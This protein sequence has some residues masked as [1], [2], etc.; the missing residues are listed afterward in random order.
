[1]VLDEDGREP[2]NGYQS[3]KPRNLRMDPDRAMPSNYGLSS[4]AENNWRHVLSLE[5]PTQSRFSTKTITK[6]Q[7][8]R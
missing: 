4:R 5:H 1:M 7:F 2:T 3:H 8:D 6:A